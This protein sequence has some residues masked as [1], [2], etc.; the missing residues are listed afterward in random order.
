MRGE[1][2]LSY[3]LS[4][5]YYIT[6]KTLLTVCKLLILATLA[7]SVYE[8][9]TGTMSTLILV[10]SSIAIIGCL[11]HMHV[12][13]NITYSQYKYQLG[14]NDYP[15]AHIS[16]TEGVFE[17]TRVSRY[18]YIPFNN[19]QKVGAL[20]LGFAALLVIKSSD[21]EETSYFLMNKKLAVD[22]RERLRIEVSNHR[23]Q[24]NHIKPTMNTNRNKAVKHG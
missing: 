22:F 6:D 8:Y 10:G 20:N 15:S 19:I 7:F 9:F 23:N 16:Y 18:S 12:T 17:L 24:H 13:V 14:H 11:I 4:K 21:P 2:R 3:E 5:L 1:S